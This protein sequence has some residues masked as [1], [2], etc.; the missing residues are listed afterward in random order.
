MAASR[1]KA[2]E[3]VRRQ[4]RSL[5]NVS[6]GAAR[7]SRIRQLDKKHASVEVYRFQILNVDRIDIR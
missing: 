4:I 7:A 2:G 5:V 1:I 3:V 6:T